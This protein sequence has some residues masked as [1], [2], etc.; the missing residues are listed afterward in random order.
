MKYE[1]KNRYTNEVITTAEG[2]ILREALEKLVTNRASLNGANLSRANLDGASL[3]GASLSRANLG[4]ASLD[5]ANLEFHQFPSIRLI[6]SIPLGNL[7]D[8]LTLELMRRDAFAHPK[9]EKFKTW[10][11]GGECP[12]QN[13]ERFWFFTEKIGLW[14]AGKPQMRDSDLIVEICKEKRWGISGHLK[15]KK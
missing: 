10:A 1:I 9:P 12:Y 7:T 4:G 14:R 15:I 2:K 13:E 5:G 11:K 6:S 8:E 3:D